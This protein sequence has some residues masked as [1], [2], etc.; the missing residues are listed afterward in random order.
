MGSFP[1]PMYPL[2]KSIVVY[3]EDITIQILIELLGKDDE[4]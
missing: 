4:Y 3:D 1:L 2:R